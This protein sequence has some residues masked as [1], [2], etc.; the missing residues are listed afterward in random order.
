MHYWFIL[1]QWIYYLTPH[2]DI[3][4]FLHMISCVYRPLLKYRTNT[5]NVWKIY[6]FFLLIQKTQNILC[7]SCC[8]SLTLNQYR[9]R[10]IQRPAKFE[11]FSKINPSNNSFRHNIS[12]IFNHIYYYLPT[13]GQNMV[14][15]SDFCHFLQPDWREHDGMA[16]TSCC[17]IK[18]DAAL[19]DV[20]ESS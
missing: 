20:C 19:S 14:E 17:L 2:K 5:V 12:S 7:W 3:S 6:C 4:Q 13:K 10:I 15:N 16:S 11:I 18:A 8:F 1:P 9:S